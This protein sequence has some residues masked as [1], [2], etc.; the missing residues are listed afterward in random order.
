MDTYKADSHKKDNSLVSCKT[1]NHP[2]TSQTTQKPAK[3]PA[4]QA[5][6]PKT[7]HKPAKPPTNQ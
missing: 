5:N 3:T 1:Q 2:E 4:N 6:Y 7:T